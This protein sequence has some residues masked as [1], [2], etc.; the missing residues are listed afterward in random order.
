MESD[1]AKHSCN[2]NDFSERSGTSTIQG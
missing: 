1:M 2:E